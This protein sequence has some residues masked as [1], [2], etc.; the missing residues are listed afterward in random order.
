MFYT[1]ENIEFVDFCVHQF[2]AVGRVD[3]IAFPSI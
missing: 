3:K 1:K 2:T